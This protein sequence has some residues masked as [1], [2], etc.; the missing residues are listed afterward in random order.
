MCHIPILLRYVCD[1]MD[2]VLTFLR[3][4]IRASNSDKTTKIYV[5]SSNI[6]TFEGDA[7]KLFWQCDEMTTE[8]E[9]GCEG[10]KNL[11]LFVGFNPFFERCQK[12]NNELG[13]ELTGRIIW[14]IV[15]QN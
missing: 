11:S 9:I 6:V 14:K 2:F 10:C 15:K 4:Q 1:E 13:G 12:E 8:N 7:T 5:H 3:L